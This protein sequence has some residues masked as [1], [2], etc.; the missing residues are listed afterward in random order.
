MSHLVKLYAMALPMA[1]PGN[2]SVYTY[3]THLLEDGVNIIAVQ[4]LLGHANIENTLV[5]LHICTPPDQL[6]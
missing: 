1:L 4:K 2:T 6:Q 3:A 5:Y